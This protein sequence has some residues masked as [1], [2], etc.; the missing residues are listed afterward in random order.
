MFTMEY[1]SGSIAENIRFEVLDGI[2][3]VV[4]AEVRVGGSYAV[5]SKLLSKET[6]DAAVTAALDEARARVRAGTET[7]LPDAAAEEP[8]EPKQPAKPRRRKKCAVEAKQVEEQPDDLTCSVEIEEEPAEE[9]LRAISEESDHDDMDGVCPDA[10]DEEDD[11]D[12]I[13]NIGEV[14]P[15]VP[16]KNDGPEMTLEEA[17]NVVFPAGAHKGETVGEVVKTDRHGLEFYAK[18]CS[19]ETY[20]KVAAAAKIVLAAQE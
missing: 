19:S 9:T 15:C 4:L 18:K 16:K 20:K 13:S 1:K 2:G 8:A 3:P 5:A 17:L 7:K 14:Q 10:A 11:C 12:L 6:Y